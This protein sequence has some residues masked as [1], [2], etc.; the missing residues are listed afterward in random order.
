MRWRELNLRLRL[1]LGAVLLGVPILTLFVILTIGHCWWAYILI[2]GQPLQQKPDPGY[3]PNL[4]VHSSRIETKI[5][6]GDYF[7]KFPYSQEFQEVTESGFYGAIENENA[8]I[9]SSYIKDG[10]LLSWIIGF[11]L[12][13]SLQGKHFHFRDIGCSPD[14][15]RSL[16]A[17]AKE[18]GIEL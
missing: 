9:R 2:T 7:V 12:L 1:Y 8:K 14:G 5:E 6:G 16:E 18:R 10:F 17:L 3:G 4:Q 15:L 13:K 11:F